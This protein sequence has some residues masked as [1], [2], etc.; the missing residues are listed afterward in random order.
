MKLLYFSFMELMLQSFEIPL[1]N[2]YV[3]KGQGELRELNGSLF[4]YMVGG[5]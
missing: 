3:F 1:Y 2:D 4:G 5:S